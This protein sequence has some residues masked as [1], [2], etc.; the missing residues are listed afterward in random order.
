MY[1]RSGERLLWSIKNSGGVWDKLG[2]GGF[3][4]AGLSTNDY[5]TLYAA[6]PH[7]LIRGGLI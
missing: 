3:S 7:G 2:A 5:S 1:Q 4:V 6:L